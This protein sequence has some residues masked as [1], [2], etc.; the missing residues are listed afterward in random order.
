MNKQ[1]RT[2]HL[3]TLLAFGMTVLAYGQVPTNAEHEKAG[4]IKEIMTA[5]SFKIES[6]STQSNLEFCEKFLQDFSQQRGIV[7]VEP[8]MT[9]TAPDASVWQPFSRQCPN[10]ELFGRYECMASDAAYSGA[11]PNQERDSY[12]KS[13]CEY[14][15]G[16]ANFKYY[17]VD[18]KNGS[19][20]KKTNIFY[21]E[22]AEGP[23]NFSDKQRV[24][25]NGGYNVIDLAKCEL[26]SSTAASDAFSYFYK[27][28]LNN[29][30]AVIK[31]RGNIA[32]FDLADLDGSDR[33]KNKPAYTLRLEGYEENAKDGKARF[34]PMCFFSSVTNTRK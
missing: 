26:T 3:L 16:T 15:R 31:Y 20:Y 13:V 9:A 14:F 2:W 5:R 29:F 25:G 7:Y 21:Y 24:N 23:L 27:R 4:R 8:K 28:P 32:I 33:D 17:E 18:T 30:N 11:L 1:N 22:R 12:R 6:H 10:L 34:V 19:K